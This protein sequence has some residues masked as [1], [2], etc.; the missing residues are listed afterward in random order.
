MNKNYFLIL[1]GLFFLIPGVLAWGPNAHTKMS[2][3]VLTD[4]S[5][6][7]GRLCGG[8]EVNKQA[9]LMGCMTPDITV[10]Y[11]YDAGGKEYKLTHNWNF[12]QELMAQ[13][14]TDDE[15][16]F[17]Y[18]VSA[19]LI[20]DGV[21]HTQAIPNAIQDMHIKNWLLHPLLEKKYDSALVQKYPELKEIT[22]HILDVIDTPRGERYMQMVD[23][24]L[25]ENSQVDVKSEMIKLR[26][27]IDSFYQTQ[28]HPSGATW[29]FKL[30]PY[31]DKVT[32]ALT[33]II[34]TMNYGAIEF[35]YKKASQNTKDIFTEWG[36][37]Y[38]VSPHGFDE[39]GKAD[40]EVGDISY[41]FI[42]GAFLIPIGLA[43]WKRKQ[44]HKRWWIYLLIIPL[45]LIA[46]IL[47]VYAM[48]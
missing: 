9:Y 12:Q 7:V 25:G 31:I 24:A 43:L 23:N 19:H 40:R 5:T 28:F 39:L 1:F 36:T 8:N 38:T 37:R 32:N 4:S 15:Q 14:V 16:C 29:I 41:Y 33:P 20:Q 17:V 18:G 47:G 30:Y 44:G 26:Y 6:F 22:P 34:G 27:A 2:Y 11:Y 3:D 42:G 45:I 46:M 13:A 48:L 21:I 35:Y 10:I